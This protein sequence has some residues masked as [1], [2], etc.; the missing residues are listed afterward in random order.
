MS[1]SQTDRGLDLFK[2]DPDR[3]KDENRTATVGLVCMVLG[4]VLIGVGLAQK[5][6]GK[7]KGSLN[8]GGATTRT[9]DVARFH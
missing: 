2:P 3:K 1:H 7:E 8:A 6:P 9:L 4:V 5:S